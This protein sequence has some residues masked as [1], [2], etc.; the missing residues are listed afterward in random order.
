ML[1]PWGVRGDFKI[2][3][4]ADR[5]R[6][7]PGLA[8]TLAGTTH[9]VERVNA[10]S[11]QLRLK[12]NNVDDRD[13][14]TALRGEYLLVA[15]ADLGPAGEG[16][17]YRFQLVGLRVVTTTGEDIGEIT[18]VFATGSNDV[19]VVKAEDGEV[20]IPAVDDV[21]QEIDLEAGK[22]TIEAIP[23]LLGD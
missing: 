22:V 10:A 1:G 23:G 3:P 21:V 16:R 5:D 19:F 2:E 4:L 14:A 13:A 18:D 7:R 12:L 17:Y 6:F 20:L 15:E 11:R 9:T 8:V